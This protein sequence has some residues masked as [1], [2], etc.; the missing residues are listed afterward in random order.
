M[1][2]R[3]KAAAARAATPEGALAR[4][5]ARDH[6]H[7]RGP[8]YLRL[9]MPAWHD[10][11][12]MRA[13]STSMLGQTLGGTRLFVRTSSSCGVRPRPRYRPSS[14]VEP[15]RSRIH[16]NRTGQKS[17]QERPGTHVLS[18]RPRPRAQV[19]ASLRACG[20]AE[21]ALR[22]RCFGCRLGWV[23]PT[24]Q[25]LLC[26]LFALRRCGAALFVNLR[27]KGLRRCLR[28]R[29]PANPRAEGR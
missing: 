18:P 17:N 8:L 20:R 5:P 2:E 6:A 29:V 14:G 7:H 16:P 11:P 10:R 28:R 19:S 1:C 4:A 24:A 12:P 27:A 25:V 13:G 26:V 15:P 22:R 3:L 21:L 23:V 9:A